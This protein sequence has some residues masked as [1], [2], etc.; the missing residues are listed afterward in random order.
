MSDRPRNIV[1]M[2]REHAHRHPDRPAYVYLEDGETE[3]TRCDFGTVDTRSRAIAAV[4]RE[5][6]L[7]GERVLIAYPSGIEYVQAFLGCL[8]AGAVAVPADLPQAVGSRHRIETIR[9]DC[10]PAAVLAPSAGQTPVALAGLLRIDVAEVPDAAADDWRDPALARADLAFLQYTSGS[11]GDPRGVMVSH[12]NILANEALIAAACRHDENSTFV[13][14]QPLFHDMG[15]VANIMQ[16]LY[17]GALSVLMPP[18]GFLQRPL[19][20]LTAISRYR[21]HT[22]GGPN[23]AYEM[24]LPFAAEAVRDGLDLSGWRVAFNAAEP[25]RESTVRAFA[26]AFAPCGFAAEASF[27]CFGLAE[28]TLLVT[29]ARRDAAPRVVRADRHAL[30]EG[31]VAPPTAA[32]REVALVSC[33][34]AG[35][36]TEVRVVD[37]ESGRACPDGATGEIWVSGGGVAAGYWRRPTESA[38]VFGRHLAESPGRTFLRTGDLGCLVD[39]ELYVTGRVKDMIVVRGQNFYPQDLE[40]IA[41]G[42]H[43]ALR[44]GAVAAF[45]VRV[46]GEERVVLCC[47]LRS[48]GRDARAAEVGYAVRARLLSRHG[49]APHT[50][51]VLRRGG[52][53]KTTS[54]KLR[55]RTCRDAY[56][57][58]RLP[59]YAE[60]TL[61]RPTGS[62]VLPAATEL[63]S[64]GR[65]RGAARLADAMLAALPDARPGSDA[66][67]VSLAEL[68][69]NSVQTLELQHALAVDYGVDL[70]LSR[71]LG[72]A[73]VAELADQVLLAMLSGT[74]R[75]ATPQPASAPDRDAAEPA[76]LT[77]A[78]GWQ[79]LTE[80]QRA[81][82]F[83]Q[84]L[85]P[86]AAYHLARAFGLRGDVDSRRLADALALLA[87]RHEALRMRF[88]ER[89]GEPYCR[90]AEEV[91]VLAHLDV[92]GLSADG[93]DRLLADLADQPFD[94]ATEPPVRMILLERG[95]GGRVLLLV[96]HHLVADFWSV[97]VLLRELGTLLDGAGT[98]VG[99]GPLARHAD[100]VAAERRLVSGA[101]GETRR[102]YWREAL[103][104]VPDLLELP[105]DRPRPA[106]RG[107]AGAVHTFRIPAPLVEA[108]RVLA[109][110]EGC[111]LFTTLLSAY[112]LLLHRLTGQP[113]LVV[114]TLAAGRADP[115]TAGT[116]GYL[117]DVLPIRSRYL[118]GETQVDRLHRTRQAVLAA[119]GHSGYPYARIVADRG[120][121]RDPGR[122]ALVQSMFVMH[123]EYRAGTVD[124]GLTALALGVPAPVQVGG[125]AGDA[126]PVARRWAQLDLLLGVAEVGDELVGSWEYRAD[127]F[128]EATIAAFGDAFVQLLAEMTHAPH[129]PVGRASPL[130]PAARGRQL[131]AGRGVRRTEGRDAAL[132]ELVAAMA[133]RDPDA[134][135]VVAPGG[136]HLTYAGLHRASATL[137]RR[138]RGRGVRAEQ[139][140]AVR[141]DR[142]LAMV[143]AYLGVLYA[144]GVVLP[145]DPA[146]PNPRQESMLRDSGAR[147][148]LAADADAAADHDG[149]VT[150]ALADSADLDTPGV[151]MPAHPAQAAYLLYTSGSTGKPKGVLVAHQA[152]V[153][154]IVWMQEHY[155]LTPGERVL[156]KTALTFD[157][158]LWELFW[159]LTTG[160]CLV[161]AEPGGHRDAG[162]LLD[163]LARERIAAVHFVPTM[164]A[165]VLAETG[166]AL[167]RDLP[168][169]RQVVCS[170]EELPVPLADAAMATLPALLDNLYGPTE[171][172][173]DVTAWRCTPEPRP[174]TPIGR[175][176][177]NVEC[178]VLDD[179]RALVVPRAPGRLHLGGVCLARGYHRRPGLTAQRFVPVPDADVGARF[180][181]TGDLAR[182]DVEGNLVYLGRDDQ[183]VKIGGVRIELGEVTETLRTQPGV[184][185]ATA[186]V[187]DERAGQPVLLGFVVPVAGDPAS[188]DTAALRERLR[189]LLPA[190][191]VPTTIHSMAALPVTASGKLDVATLTRQRP[192]PPVASADPPRSPIERRIAGLCGTHLGLDEV[193]MDRDFFA[194]GGDSIRALR[195]VS[196]A[197]AAGLALTVGDVLSA[198]SIRALAARV[199][200]DSPPAVERLAPFAL[201]PAA[202]GRPGLVDAYPISMAQ[203]S[204]LFHQ[205]HNPSY[206]VYVSSV[207]VA[208]RLDATAL[209][210]AVDAIVD[211]HPYLRSSFDLTSYDQ[212]AQLVHA[213]LPAALEIVDLR[214]FGESLRRAAE[215]DWLRAEALRPFDTASGPL[216]RFAGHVG[217][218]SFRLTVSS[219][220]L[221]GWCAATVLTELLTDY[222]ARVSGRPPAIAPPE[223]SYA[224][225]VGAERAAVADAD[226]L[227][228]WRDELAGA[229][230]TR[231]PMRR[232]TGRTGVTRRVVRVDDA[233]A[234][235]MRS[236]TERFAVGLKHV[237]LAAHLRAVGELCEQPE[238]VTGLEVN[239]RLPVAGGDRVIGVF[240]NIVPLRTR[241]DGSWAELVARA[242]AVESRL[243]PYRRFPL[244]EAQRRFGAAALFD[245]LFVFTHFHLYEQ[246]QTR[247]GLPVRDLYAP[248]QTYLPLTAHFHVDAW[249]GDLH[250]LIDADAG[251]L[252]SE[253]TNL[254]ES[255]YLRAMSL[256]AADPGDPV[257]AVTAPGPARRDDG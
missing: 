108:L 251:Q 214:G 74:P 171:A 115:A 208:V 95:A 257:P 84:Q 118:P 40:Q 85:A 110:T 123:R 72:G 21:A 198:P 138:L 89:D 64:L 186:V 244:V 142:S 14:W 133:R 183:Q 226:Q 211:R 103:D 117:V 48:Y 220:A 218:E 86:G 150:L 82:W 60:L 169:L 97:V 143:V 224:D 189:G 44:P 88:V 111:T 146:E 105:V 151:V 22:S 70:G 130:D 90:A 33:G 168:W 191:M 5:R 122:A 212:P 81:L 194:L 185:A 2:A 238:I 104:G 9:G 137:A 210:A 207:E 69:A 163:V 93:V 227:R 180:Y 51:V 239:G 67:A 58:G 47:E 54:G 3:S 87:G 100:L 197:R 139:V 124:D 195:L 201:C 215:G 41:E 154:R 27:P 241:T 55:R 219:F 161:L 94:L 120:T 63:T 225:F 173:V 43:A 57:D 127:L 75:P 42:A 7:T 237:L 26:E 66:A 92:S 192:T 24:C 179:Q 18:T 228:F 213:R 28:A 217:D 252:G 106:R 52:V 256:L 199:G 253:E 29:G 247:T 19:R 231:L 209:T 147:L 234:T 46:G 32:D 126:L 17:L 77:C 79:P 250:L 99:C 187:T 23:F 177:A 158:S 98:S 162:Y 34:P 249:S 109:R 65:E 68:G 102:Q 141:L 206:Q 116:I 255:C 11:T 121:R 112:Q 135:A 30:G 235:G 35:L 223:A 193:D 167:A 6:G 172:A 188:V 140:V 61:D 20:W 53:P 80:R 36:D 119:I 149:V 233:I 56:L 12:G 184:A 45:G 59:V 200:T 182:M 37:T 134:V 181:D 8:Y 62:A 148:M 174:R 96:A 91:P 76:G 190:A 1:D 145:L 246:V 222:G 113:D 164:L 25:V 71:L 4:L 131:T 155:R 144:G 16:P 166:P 204:L 125:L 129:A 78:D 136:E 240:N 243:A 236:A 216:V 175:P 176:I 101:E 203:R 205:G 229:P 202:A 15:L 242:R 107:F 153:N 38:D 248:D 232:A 157:V 83:E 50:L 165:S 159:P 245:T 152:I 254:I 13:G 230:T 196:A 178:R 114:G 132:H 73:S 49:I 160:G 156:Q 39:G 221:D 170:G 128:H 10:A 31:R